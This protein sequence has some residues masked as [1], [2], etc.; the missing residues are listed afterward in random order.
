MNNLSE[1]KLVKTVIKRRIETLYLVNERD[2]DNL[3]TNS[4]AADILILL[5][6]VS[7]GMYFSGNSPIYL[8]VGLLAILIALFFYYLKV[9]FIRDTKKSGEVEEIKK[10][11]ITDFIIK[12]ATYGTTDDKTVDVTSRLV[13]QVKNN[14]L[15]VAATNE[16]AG[17]DPDPGTVKYLEIEYEYG[18]STVVKKYRE[19][20][21]LT[22]L[23]M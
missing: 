21:I 4:I 3:K 1:E 9:D 18:G 6:S 23:R 2:L 14:R 7:L 16:I 11:T 22:S 13:S 5:A 19:M 20:I 17:N 15:N 8:A 12:R 10:A